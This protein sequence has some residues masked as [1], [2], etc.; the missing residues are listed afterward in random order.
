MSETDWTDRTPDTM[1]TGVWDDSG[2]WND[3]STWADYPIWAVVAD[4][5]TDSE[6]SGG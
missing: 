1:N 3:I 5:R 2:V 4:A 6:D